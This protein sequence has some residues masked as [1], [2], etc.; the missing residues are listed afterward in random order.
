ML[1]VNI[2]HMYTGGQKRALDA[3]E[4]ELQV[5]VIYTVLVPGTK[6]QTPVRAI[7]VLSLLQSPSPA[8]FISS[9][10]HKLSP[11]LGDFFLVFP[12]CR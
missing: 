12:L 11:T 7:C 3:L 2:S 9:S 6:L 5:P 4:L 10:Q 8:P 1:N